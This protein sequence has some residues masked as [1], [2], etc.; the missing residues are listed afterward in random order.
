MRDVLGIQPRNFRDSI[1]EM[2]YA[3]IEAGFVK[4]TSKYRGPG[5]AEER[6]RYL[7]APLS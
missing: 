3:L 2:A 1:I 5:G 4:R 6:Q 7:E